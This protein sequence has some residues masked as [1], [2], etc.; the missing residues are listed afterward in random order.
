MYFA[1]NYVNYVLIWHVAYFV[2][3]MCFAV[4][5]R[6]CIVRNNAFCGRDDVLEK[7]G[8]ALQSDTFCTKNLF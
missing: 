8:F 7:I 3:K 1:K 5:A 4:K 6:H 2:P